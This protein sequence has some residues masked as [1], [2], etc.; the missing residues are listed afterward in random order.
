MNE[1]DIAN[2]IWGDMNTATKEGTS[3]ASALAELMTERKELE[4]TILRKTAVIVNQK[5]TLYSS[6]AVIAVWIVFC[7]FLPILI[8]AI[9]VGAFLWGL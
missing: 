7:F 9:K 8:A 1:R 5:A 3:S 6:A 2:G 4:L